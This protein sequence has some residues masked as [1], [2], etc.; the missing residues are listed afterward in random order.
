MISKTRVGWEAGVREVAIRVCPWE[1]TMRES[2]RPRPEE[3]PVINQVKGREG[4]VN[5]G[6]DMI[7]LLGAFP[8]SEKTCVVRRYFGLNCKVRLIDMV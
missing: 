1:R 4:V 2:V 5:W 8:F 6:S 7:D 3:Q